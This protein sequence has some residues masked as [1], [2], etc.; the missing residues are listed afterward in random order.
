MICKPKT[1]KGGQIT[2][3]G[4]FAFTLVA[5]VVFAFAPS[6]AAGEKSPCLAGALSWLVPGLGQVYNEQY[7]KGAA[8]FGA[9]VLG[10][11][12]GIIGASA[13]KTET[14]TDPWTGSTYEQEVSDP[15]EALMYGGYGIAVVSGIWS[16]ID[17]VMVASKGGG[18]GYGST[19]QGLLN[20]AIKSGTNKNTTLKFDM[21]KL[22]YHPKDNTLK[23]TLVD[24]TF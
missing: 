18:R 4:I 12:M 16:I 6:F 21:P 11:T 7:G 19:N 2:R 10:I 8:F 23:L 22:A 17:A 9:S 24:A 1:F 13:T 20:F 14:Y 5:V 3:R 15:N